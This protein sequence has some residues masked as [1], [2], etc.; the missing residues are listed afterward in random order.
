M[1]KIYEIK[2][3]PQ[4]FTMKKMISVLKT[5]EKQMRSQG[6]KKEKLIALSLED[7]T[8]SFNKKLLILIDDNA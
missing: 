3:T 4:D 8:V 7:D 2:V 6:I 1:H 5:A